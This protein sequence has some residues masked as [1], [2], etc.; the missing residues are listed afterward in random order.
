MYTMKNTVNGQ[1]LTGLE[2]KRVRAIIKNLA[3]QGVDL[4]TIEVHQGEHTW[5]AYEF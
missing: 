4:M 3:K 2:L 5:L 1:T